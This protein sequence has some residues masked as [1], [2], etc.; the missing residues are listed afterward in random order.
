M[1]EAPHPDDADHEAFLKREE[2]ERR[3]LYAPA[4]PAGRR[5]LTD[6]DGVA[7]CD[8]VTE[9]LVGYVAAVVAPLKARI[10]Q[11]EAQRGL[12]YVGCWKQGG[13]YKCGEFVSYGGG[14]WH[15][16]Q[17]TG[18]RPNRCHEAWQ[19]A[20]KSGRDAARGN[21]SKMQSPAAFRC[22]KEIAA[23]ARRA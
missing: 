6:K 16:K 19:L 2:A 3:K 13:D 20:V 11:L 18:T 9:G 15:C 7:I 1:D 21:P 23:A 5:Y 8:V 17:N 4:Q 12:K 22:L 10:A 14:V